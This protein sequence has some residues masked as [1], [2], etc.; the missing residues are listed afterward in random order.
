MANIYAAW[1]QLTGAN[2]N[3]ASVT[4]FNTFF[5]LSSVMPVY[6]RPG[7]HLVVADINTALIYYI[8]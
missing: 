4:S 6:T 2:G 3:V 7:Q 5:P 8:S 1:R